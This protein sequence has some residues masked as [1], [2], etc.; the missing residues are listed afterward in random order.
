MTGELIPTGVTFGTGRSSINDSFSGTA[1]FN[2]VTLDGGAVIA[3]TIDTA[4]DINITGNTQISGVTV[5][6]GTLFAGT[7]GGIFS[8]GTD[9]YDIFSGSSFNGNTSGD[10]ISDIWVSN[11]HSCSPLAI[12]PNNEGD[13]HIGELSA[14][15]FDLTNN[16]LGI[17]IV[18]TGS[19]DTNPLD[20]LELGEGEWLG[21]NTVTSPGV[22]STAGI[23]FKEGVGA[24]FVGY[25]VDMY[26][27]ATGG[28][29][30]LI[31]EGVFAGARQ[32]GMMVHRGGGVGIGMDLTG[33]TASGTLQIGEVGNVATLKFVDGNQANGYV[34]TS[35]SGGTA[36]WQAGGGGGETNTASSVGSG[37]S[38][39]KQKTGVD[40]EFR[41]ISAGTNVTITTGDTIT[42][43]SGGDVYD[44]GT[45]SGTVDWYPNNVSQS[46]NGEITLNGNMTLNINSAQDG[47]FGTLKITQDGIGSHSLTLGSGTHRV[48]NGGGGSITL[49]ATAGATDIITFFYANSTFWWNVGND[50]T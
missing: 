45:T 44:F 47:Q 5:V 50:Y 20:A 22:N 37:N 21:F 25:G 35:D 36:T 46:I 30:R 14:N 38:L 9:L 39:F 1:N 27:N 16:R 41:S 3:G 42:I 8:G 43:N 7:G 40:L 19:R 18:A 12:N 10:C 28:D 15:T 26:Y 24:G 11:L 23:H 48:S 31:I 33:S 4:G 29:D 6:Y 32:G 17:G 34:L 2:N 49:T 13:I